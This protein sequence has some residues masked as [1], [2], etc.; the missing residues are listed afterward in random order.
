MEENYEEKKENYK[1]KE[2]ETIEIKKL[3]GA[4]KV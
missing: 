3:G 2:K 1:K 4:S